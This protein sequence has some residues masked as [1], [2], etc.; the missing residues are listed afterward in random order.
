M[1]GSD[2]QEIRDA[3]FELT[4]FTVSETASL[5]AVTAALVMVEPF[6]VPVTSE[7]TRQEIARLKAS[8][9][10]RD[11]SEDDLTMTYTV[12]GEECAAWPPDV[13]REALRGWAK[14]EKFFPSL[15][16]VRAEL[17]R[18]GRARQSLKNALQQQERR[19]G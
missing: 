1:L 16:E 17:Q 18:H 9:V 15:A 4:G 2:C 13:V 7:V 14:R 12:I 19:P 6:L 8:C 5:D 11:F 3:N 10:M